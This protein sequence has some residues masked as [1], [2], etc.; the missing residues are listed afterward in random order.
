MPNAVPYVIWAGVGHEVVGIAWL[1][2]METVAVA[3]V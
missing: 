2:A 1:T 3:E